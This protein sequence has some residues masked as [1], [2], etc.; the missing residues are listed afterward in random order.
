MRPLPSKMGPDPV[1][2]AVRQELHCAIL[3]GSE[4]GRPD[5]L[6]PGEDERRGVAD[7]GLAGREDSHLGAYAAQKPQGAGSPPPVVGDL[8]DLGLQRFS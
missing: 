6:I 3:V 1:A 4:Q 2:L 7:P 5:L 8:Q